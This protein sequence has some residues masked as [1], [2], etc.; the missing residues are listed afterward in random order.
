MNLIEELTWRGLIHDMTPGTADQLEKEMTTG[1]VGFDPTADSLHIGNLVPI[2]MLV[3][4]QRAGHKPIALVGGATGMIGDPSGKVEER[5][6]LSE[7]ILQHNLSR[8]KKQLE[9]FLDF[10]CGENSAEIVN[11]YDWFKDMGVLTFLREAG[12]YLTINYMMAKESVKKRVNTGL[13]FT[14]FS[15]QLIQGYDFFWLYKNKNC[16]LQMGG[17]DQWGNIVTGTEF[18]RR[19]MNG[20]A[21]ALTAP[22]ITRSDGRKFGKSESGNIW[23]DPERTSPYEMYQYWLNVPD[24]DA[25]SYIKLFTFLEKNEIEGLIAEHRKAPHIRILQKRLAEEVTAMIHS[26]C[27]VEEAVEAS[28]ILFGSGTTESL[29]K[30]NENTFLSVF[31]GVPQYEVL[32]GVLH[33]QVSVTDMLVDHARVFQSKGELKRLIKGG[34]LSINKKKI[35][36]FEDKISEKDLLNNKYILVQKGKK[37]YY[38]I[39]VK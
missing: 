1:Y 19:K 24:I 16:K 8:Q 17:S 33:Q 27:D 22:L 37:N 39:K 31:D 36:D 5:S 30:L 13:S 12:K 20:E 32:S 25:E 23:L 7:E 38:I 28:R 15:Y 4:L 14:E 9:K 21:Y 26:P 35:T 18:I 3:H 11:N 2:T 29:K 6:F 10:N 34:G